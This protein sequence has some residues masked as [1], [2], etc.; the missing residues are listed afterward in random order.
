MLATWPYSGHVDPPKKNCWIATE[1]ERDENDQYSG[2]PK[3]GKL[4]AE[5]SEA[6]A[7]TSE[8]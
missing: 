4:T 5:I 7:W 3:N 1:N 8:D 2:I 6:T